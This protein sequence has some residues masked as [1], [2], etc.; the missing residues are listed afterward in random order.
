MGDEPK[1]LK[2]DMPLTTGNTSAL[3]DE[4]SRKLYESARPSIVQTITDGGLGTG[5]AVAPNRIVTDAHCVIGEKEIKVIAKDGT[6]Y[7]ARI[8]DMDDT[9]D[10]ALLEIVSDKPINF[11]PLPLGASSDLK[12]DDKI[13]ALGH[14]KGLPYVYISPGYYREHNT[15]KSFWDHADLPQFGDPSL[16]KMTPKERSDFDEFQNRKLIGGRVHIEHGNSGGPLLN[17]AGK[18]VGVS[19]LGLKDTS[20]TYYT[21]VERVNA[22]L[23]RTTPKFQFKEQWQ[24]A[25][26]INDY[27]E[28]WAQRPAE[29]A[30]LTGLGGAGAYMSR[31][32]R[33]KAEGAGVL[34]GVLI[35]DDASELYNSDHARDKAKY[36]AA[37]T[38]DAM[39][40]GGGAINLMTRFQAS[41]KLL[42]KLGPYGKWI[43]GGG[44][45]LRVGS[46]FIPNHL[47]ITDQTRTDGEVRAPFAVDLTH[48][49]PKS[50]TERL[51]EGGAAGG[52]VNPNAG[53]I[54]QTPK[55]TGEEPKP[56]QKRKPE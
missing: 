54:E 33:N 43:A 25:P 15:Q 56:E 4:T 3:A 12:P 24:A 19:D 45:A 21:P 41:E 20:D 27:K 53:S 9:H 50:A 13:F 31:K 55:P 48:L 49:T 17:E 44:L 35:I 18:V 7:K 22:M 8:V 38:G 11:A 10:L 39:M 32:I 26:W 37:T 2:I 30:T 47:T 23:G 42:G 34:G 29:T 36:A 5:F 46:E 51:A 28:S 40:V 16:F 6:K 1:V 14:P 52:I